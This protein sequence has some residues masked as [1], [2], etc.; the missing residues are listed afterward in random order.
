MPLMLQY[1]LSLFSLRGRMGFLPLYALR[2]SRERR[3]IRCGPY[4]G[5]APR[6]FGESSIRLPSALTLSNGLSA[7]KGTKMKGPLGT[8]TAFF[9]H[10]PPP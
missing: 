1:L 5:A 10:G 7:C 4:A 3:S 9:D 8:F 6:Q 2:V